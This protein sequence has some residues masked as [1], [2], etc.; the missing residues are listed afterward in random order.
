MPKNSYII[1]II[2]MLTLTIPSGV[3]SKQFAEDIGIGSKSSERRLF[4]VLIN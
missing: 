2:C 3:L 4:H 1:E